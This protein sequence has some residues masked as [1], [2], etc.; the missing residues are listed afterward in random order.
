MTS[1][2]DLERAERDEHEARKAARLSPFP[3]DRERFLRIAQGA[4]DRLAQARQE[5]AGH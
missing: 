2:T 3:A 4:A 1:L 5:T